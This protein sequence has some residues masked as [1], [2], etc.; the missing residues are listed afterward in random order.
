MRDR[1]S[2][3]RPARPTQTA[4]VADETRI[5]ILGQSNTRGVQLSEPVAAWP[6]LLATA[7]PEL[8]GS[9]VSITVRPF[10]AHVPGSQEYLE[11]ELEKHDPDIVFLMVTTFSFATPVIEPEMRRRF[12]ARIGQAYG[13]LAGRFDDSTRNRGNVAR[14]M[15]RAVRTVAK[16]V[17][18]AAPVSA[19]D[20]ALDGTVGALRLLARTEAVQVAAF[21]GFVK[22][23]PGPD[24]RQSGRER[25]VR[26]F[27]SEV[28]QAAE[29]LHIVFMN[30]QDSPAIDPATWFMPD[31]LHVTA[32]AHEAIAA[33][34]LDAFRDGRLRTLHPGEP[35]RIDRG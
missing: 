25:Q 7:L 8:T 33:T 35:A 29:S 28:R 12:G 22:F 34:V 31:G 19:Y 10:F 20:I 21:H 14:G 26:Q 27:L 15:N 2:L 32:L 18:P 16:R 11:R 30:M 24:G 13:R 9:P 4:V 17:L 6:N 23:S 1:R 5:L 3:V